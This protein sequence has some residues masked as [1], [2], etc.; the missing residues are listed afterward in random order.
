MDRVLQHL[1]GWIS[2]FALPGVLESLK[3]RDI[4]FQWD[5]LLLEAGALAVLVSPLFHGT[6]CD[7]GCIVS[8]FS[9]D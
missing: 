1:R 9:V 7:S 3:S 5:I 8:V 4:S 6:R 2:V